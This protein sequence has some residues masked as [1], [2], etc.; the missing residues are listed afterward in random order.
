VYLAV[1]EVGTAVE[2]VTQV[3]AEEVLAVYLGTS[4]QTT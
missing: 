4:L 1:Q 2:A 3:V